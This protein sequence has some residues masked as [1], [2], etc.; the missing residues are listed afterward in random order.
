MVIALIAVIVI[1]HRRR[2]RRPT[3]TNDPS[4]DPLDP[5]MMQVEHRSDTTPRPAVDGTEGGH[6]DGVVGFEAGTSMVGHRVRIGEDGAKLAMESVLEWRPSEG[7]ELPSRTL[8]SAHTSSNGAYAASGKFSEGAG[9]SGD[10]TEVL[11]RLEMLEAERRMLPPP[12]VPS[13]AT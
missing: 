12:Y 5:D 10:L 8:V 1:V 13:D 9:S 6:G 11:R 2:T 3:S 7:D 4:S